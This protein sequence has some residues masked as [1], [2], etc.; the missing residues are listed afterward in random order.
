MFFVY[1][2][3]FRKVILVFSFNLCFYVLGQVVMLFFG[4]YF[5]GKYIKFFVGV[6]SG[7]KSI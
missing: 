4:S 7:G 3:W 6:I 2:C 5:F 1:F